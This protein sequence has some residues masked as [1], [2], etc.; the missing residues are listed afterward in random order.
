MLFK[1]GCN[2]NFFEGS[3]LVGLNVG[4]TGE[5]LDIKDVESAIKKISEEINYVF[6]GTITSTKIL[7]AGKNKNY[8]EN[9]ILVWTSI[10]PRFPVEKDNFKSEFIKFVG[11]LATELKQERTSINFTD[12]SLMLETEYCKNPDLK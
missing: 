4:D 11:E 2:I 5:T 3:V 10:Y 9:A 1:T 7:V 12:E 8:E 6:S